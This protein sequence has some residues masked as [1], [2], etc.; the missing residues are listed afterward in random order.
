MFF[1]DDY[2]KFKMIMVQ[3]AFVYVKAQVR[4]RSWNDQLEI[5]ISDIKL[6]SM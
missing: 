5:R 6:L 2:L 3:G 4:K 1:R